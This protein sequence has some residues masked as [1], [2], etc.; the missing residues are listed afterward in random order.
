MEPIVIEARPTS[1]GDQAQVSGA[2]VDKKAN[3]RAAN[4]DAAADISA[5]KS[6]TADTGNDAREMDAQTP[7]TYLYLT[8]DTPL[9]TPHACSPRHGDG[10]GV[11]LPPCPD[12]SAYRNPLTWPRFRK[13][14]MVFLSC[15]ATWGTAYTA[16]AYSQ[17]VDLIAAELGTTRIGALV[18][19]TTFCMGFACAPMI[20]APFSEINGRYPVFAIAG[21]MFTVFQAVSGV[22]KTLAGMLVARFL[23]GVG[24][25]VFSTMV[26]GVIADM[27]DKEDR[28]TPMA[29]FS[30]SVLVGTGSGPLVAAVMV[31]H[32]GG[33]GQTWKWIFWHQVILDFVL[34]VAIAVLFKE[35]RGSVL[36]SRKAKALNKW[37]EELEANGVYGMWVQG[38]RLSEHLGVLGDA[39]A[40]KRA[41]LSSTRL[42]RIRWITKEDEQRGSLASMVTTSLFRPFHFLFTEPIVFFFTLWVSF[43]WAIL[44]LTFASIPLVFKRQ[45]DFTTE[46]CG[47]VF[48][49]MVVGSIVA[50]VIGVYQENILKH[51]R[52]QRKTE[53]SESDTSDNSYVEPSRFWGF[54]RRNFPA[55]SHESRLY[56]T[57]LTSVLLPLGLYLFGFSA[58]PSIHWIVPTLAVGIATT[59]IFYVYLATF[60]YLADIYQSYASSALAAQSFGRNV[61]GGIFPLVAGALFT[62]LGEDAAG[63]LLGGIATAL[64]VV[65][66]VLVFFGERIRARSAFAVVSTP[67]TLFRL[68][69][70]TQYRL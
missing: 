37:Y 61:L 57:C 53:W 21:V 65:P 6:S 16:G 47:F 22:V 18:G 14:V 8:F 54:L 36:L 33:E 1:A 39:D 55:E 59:G 7:I 27:Y 42:Q 38:E 52:W 10:D 43:A 28:N 35:S 13:D 23:T 64:T 49:A 46:Q 17:P 30:G 15:V 32:W 26:G 2:A 29:L 19:V 5:A 11:D 66:W 58:Q 24:G 4:A 20:L 68:V 40:E 69:L 48:V 51:R 31:Q 45:Y 63:G 34:M 56:F 12:L 44:Y 50:T 67:E 25:S 60:N 41:P 3:A 62:N 9:P 70:L